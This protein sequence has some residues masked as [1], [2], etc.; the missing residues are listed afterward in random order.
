[1]IEKPEKYAD[2]PDLF[3]HAAE[4]DALS[5]ILH[6]VRLR[7][8][9]LIRCAP[10]PPFRIE[11][12]P[13]LRILHIAE[14]DGIRIEVGGAEISLD[15]GDMVLL[16]R[17]DPHS[18]RAGAEAVARPLTA[19]DRHIDGSDAD[20]RWVSGSFAVENDV[21]GPLLAV[22]PE[23]I[24][25]RAGTADREW[26][27]LSLQLLLVEV[28]DPRPG[29]WVMISRILDLLFVHALREWSRTAGSTPGWL[30]AAV[31]VQLAP[32]LT[33]IHKTPEYPW[34]VSELAAR[35]RQSRSTFAERFTR[36][37][38]QSPAAYIAARRLDRAAYLLRSTT[39]SVGSIAREVGYASDSAFTRAFQRR[40]DESPLR[41]RRSTAQ[42]SSRLVTPNSPE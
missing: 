11:V 24:V 31:D 18:I 14:T 28:V 42:P 34:T 15:A 2:H 7:G 9:S 1:M 21:A 5:D 40:Y 38:G 36:L 8:D 35:A 17:G 16:A 37:L 26:L 33:A 30:T 41:W 13:G 23:A 29:A 39:A 25:V 4:P 3:E 32:V 10:E 20:P 22:L 6:T 12:S 19:A 27:L